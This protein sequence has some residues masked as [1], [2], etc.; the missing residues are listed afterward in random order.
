MAYMRVFAE[1]H[2]GRTVERDAFAKLS[3]AGCGRK[4]FGIP[5]FLRGHLMSRAES[6]QKHILNA[7]E[8]PGFDPLMEYRLQFGVVNLDGHDQLAF[9]LSPFSVH[10]YAAACHAFQ[11]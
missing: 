10:G 3:D 9:S 6:F 5:V 1:R 4:G 7:R 11:D 2:P 8:V